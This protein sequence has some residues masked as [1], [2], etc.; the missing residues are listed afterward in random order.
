MKLNSFKLLTF[1]KNNK[2][3]HVKLVTNQAAKLTQ[4]LMFIKINQQ[5]RYNKIHE[6][7]PNL[8]RKY[9]FLSFLQRHN[10]RKKL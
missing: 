1:L 7:K 10:Y 3:V 9:A 2:F 4:V 5:T 8:A 6:K